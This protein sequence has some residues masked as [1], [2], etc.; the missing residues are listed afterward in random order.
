MKSHSEKPAEQYKHYDIGIVQTMLSF[1]FILAAVTLLF[2]NLG[3]L[4]ST[5]TAHWLPLLL[6]TFFGLCLADFVTGVVHWLADSYGSTRAAVVGQRIIQPFRVH[7]INP[8]DF[9]NRSF[10]DTNG[11]T[12]ILATLA[13][14]GMLFWD[15]ESTG[16]ELLKA[17]TLAFLGVVTFANQFHKW[18]HVRRPPLFVRALQRC[19]FILTNDAHARH[20]T[21]PHCGD[22]CIAL[23]WCNPILERVQFF[24]RTERLIELL[25]GIQARKEEDSMFEEL[26]QVSR[27]QRR[28]ERS[29]ESA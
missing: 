15:H 13:L 28:L 21:Y 26:K 23:G 1:C 19:R 27:Q 16:A 2:F 12:S 24:R 17:G 14:A 25:T 22:Y 8:S 5:L 29:S 18:A 4:I 6:A 11:D 7:H 20:H 9:L 10:V 3:S